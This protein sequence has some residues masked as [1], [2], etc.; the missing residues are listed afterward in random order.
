MA[1]AKANF[2]L[3]GH[4]VCQFKKSPTLSYLAHVI[5]GTLFLA[6]PVLFT[7]TSA[8]LVILLVVED[9][10]NKRTICLHNASS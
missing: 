10:N 2:R 1:D 8:N 3:I 9:V 7:F 6:T 4:I 5:F